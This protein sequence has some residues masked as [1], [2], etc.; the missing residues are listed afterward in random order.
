MKTFL[1]LALLTVAGF[2]IYQNRV[3]QQQRAEIRASAQDLAL[4]SA[5]LN[6]QNQKL[7][8]CDMLAPE[9]DSQDPEPNRQINFA[10]GLWAGTSSSGIYQSR[11]TKLSR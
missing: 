1:V 4:L 7:Q 2:N 8:D 6:E 3:I 11:D 9:P 10:G 5:I